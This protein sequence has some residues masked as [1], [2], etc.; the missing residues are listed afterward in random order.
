MKRGSRMFS[1]AISFCSHA[2]CCNSRSTCII[3][4]RRFD[5][6]HSAR[7]H[8]FLLYYHKISFS[9]NSWLMDTPKWFNRFE[10]HSMQFRK[11]KNHLLY[12]TFFSG[13][14]NS[15]WTL[16]ST[17]RSI[18]R[19]KI[20][21]HWSHVPFS[22][23]HRRQGSWSLATETLKRSRGLKWHR[24]HTRSNANKFLHQGETS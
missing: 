5:H 2:S 10:Y 17:L 13:L 1:W 7:F 23:H 21:Y 3:G 4:S 9:Q 22:L 14:S 24:R 12:P 11:K 15:L 19:P 6:Q 20:W 8:L 18:S 16:I